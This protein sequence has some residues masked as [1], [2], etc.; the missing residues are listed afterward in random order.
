MDMLNTVQTPRANAIGAIPA[1]KAARPS[2]A[3]PAPHILPT[4][5]LFDSVGVSLD[6]T[7]NALAFQAAAPAPAPAPT[8]APA[9]APTTPQ[10]TRAYAKLPDTTGQQFNIAA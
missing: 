2:F 7:S 5:S 3:A 8:P 4:G 6:L 10:A 1:G 9:P